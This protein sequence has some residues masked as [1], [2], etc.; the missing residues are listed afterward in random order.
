MSKQLALG[1]SLRESASLENFVPGGNAQAISHLRHCTEGSGE[2]FLYMWGPEGSGKSHLLQAAC[3]YADSLSK[4]AAYVP[5]S[6]AEL[7]EP[8][9][10][11]DLDTM[12]LVCLDDVDAIVGN[13]NWEIALF[14][15]FNR[16]RDGKVSLITTA[17]QGPL[18]LPLELPDLRSRLSWGLSYQLQAL[19]DDEKIQALLDGANRRGLTMSWDTGAYI[20]RHAPR[21]MQ[22][23]QRLIEHL[24]RGSLEAQRRLTTPFVKSLLET[25]E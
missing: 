18:N 3:Q 1:I 8:E 4:S 22:S 9:I 15:L 24:D 13:G 17:S 16:L 5:L 14:H 23:L 19:R 12:D 25:F 10:L 7:F 21:D 20:L 11:A 2:Q 6:Q